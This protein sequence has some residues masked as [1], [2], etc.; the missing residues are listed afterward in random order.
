MPLSTTASFSDIVL[1]AAG[2]YEKVDFRFP[3]AHINFLTFTDKAVEP[4]GEAKPEWEIFTLLA[5]KIQERARSRGLDS[6]T[7]D[8]GRSFSLRDLYDVFTLHGAIK[9][10]DGEKLAEEMVK[11]TVRVGA[12]PEKTDLKE[13]RKRGVIRFTGLGADAVGLALATDIKPDET[14]SH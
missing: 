8:G 7:D 4:V 9:E 5:R 2:S 11:D 6:Y 13:V 3:T 14:I 10:R 1:P 12:L